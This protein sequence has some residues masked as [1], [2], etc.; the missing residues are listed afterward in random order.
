MRREAVSSQTAQRTEGVAFETKEKAEGV[1]LDHTEEG[2]DVLT[3][4]GKAGVSA[5]CSLRHAEGIS[6]DNGGARHC[7]RARLE[8]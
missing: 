3:T 1:G 5:P 2:S 7:S 4:K 6:Q 8:Q